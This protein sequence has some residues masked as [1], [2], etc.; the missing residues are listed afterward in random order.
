ME[1]DTVRFETAE[2]DERVGFLVLDRPAVLNAVNDQLIA[3]FKQACDALRHAPGLCVVVLKAEGRGFCSGMDLM[4]AAHRP[5]DSETL[6][7]VWAPW[8][9]ALDTLEQLDQL[10]IAA[11]HGPCL[12]A[13][14]E[15]VLACDFRIATTSAFFGLPQILYGTPP[16][17]GQNYRLPQL[18]GLAK[19]KE[20]MLLGQRFSAA[21]A[22]RWGLVTRLVEPGDL[23]AETDALVERCL[24]LGGKAAAGA[25]HLLHRTWELDNQ[26]L[27]AAIHRARASALEDG[28]FAASLEVYRDRRKPQV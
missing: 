21:E 19:A 18:I 4:A 16:D 5:H 9:Q 8:G 14:L 15:L 23:G 7:A 24:Q 17:V 22:E 27:A 3:D 6:E 11:I 25:K 13:G 1:W 12:G 2:H 28:A 20:I 10:T 26:A